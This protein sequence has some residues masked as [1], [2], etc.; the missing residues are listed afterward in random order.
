MSTEKSIWTCKFCGKDTSEVEYD[1]LSGYDHLGC[2]L[3]NDMKSK[4]IAAFYVGY[5]LHMQN[6][7]IS[8]IDAGILKELDSYVS[9][10]TI[11]VLNADRFLYLQK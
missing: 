6:P 8:I 7:Y 2:A 4:W 5:R 10:A 1:Y 9:H 3:Q 11:E